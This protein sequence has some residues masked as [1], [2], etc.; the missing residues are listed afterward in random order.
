MMTKAGLG[1]IEPVC[2]HLYSLVACALLDAQ[3]VGVAR[4]LIHHIIW[5]VLSGPV[6]APDTS[7][8]GSEQS[9]PKLN[10]C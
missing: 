3:K 9:L 8:A 2:S 4:D 6:K 5:D 7:D 10:I 1:E